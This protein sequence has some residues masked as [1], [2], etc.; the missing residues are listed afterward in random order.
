MRNAEGWHYSLTWMDNAGVLADIARAD[1]A[2]P[3]P[4]TRPL[5]AQR[6]R[7]TRAARQITAA[8][9]KNAGPPAIRLFNSSRPP[10]S[11]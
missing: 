2:P 1:K 9:E 11:R 3:A 4:P 10:R 6:V 8:I 5:R 7:S